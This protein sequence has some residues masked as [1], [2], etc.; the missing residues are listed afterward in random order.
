MDDSSGHYGDSRRLDQDLVSLALSTVVLF[1]ELLG[2]LAPDGIRRSVVCLYSKQSFLQPTAMALVVSVCIIPCAVF[3]CWIVF[4][5]VSSARPESHRLPRYPSKRCLL[6]LMVIWYITLV[7]VLKTALSVFLCVNVHDSAAFEEVDATHMYWAVDTAIKCYEG[8][9]RILVYGVV[10]GFVCPVYGGLLAL[11]TYVLK[12]PF[13]HLIYKRGWAYQTTGFL[14]RSYRMDRRRY[15]EI[16]IIARK[17][18]IAF[19][20]FSA[21]LFDSGVPI[22]GVAYTIMLAILAQSLAMPYREEFKDLNR[23]ELAS[24]F[25]SLATT[26]AASMLKDESYPENITR[27]LLTGVCAFLNVIAFFWF[28]FYTLDFTV[29]FLKHKLQEHGEHFASDAGKF[30][31]LMHWISYEVRHQIAKLRPT[32]EESEIFDSLNVE[33]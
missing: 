20:V 3:L 17:A 4:W 12:S 7:P 26:L 28:C 2:G 30:R 16:A 23:I 11:F 14:Y 8:D 25:V 1:T 5:A 6:T 33:D 13:Q 9:H 32:S 18:M 31:I 10:A 21:H 27:M 22:I 19:L 29:E 24:L 15:W